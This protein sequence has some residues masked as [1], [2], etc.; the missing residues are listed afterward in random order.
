MATTGGAQRWMRWRQAGTRARGSPQQSLVPPAHRLKERNIAEELIP[1]QAKAVWGSI[2]PQQGAIAVLIYS[3]VVDPT[4]QPWQGRSVET[5]APLAFA[6]G[7]LMAQ[8]EAVDLS[9]PDDEEYLRHANQASQHADL[10]GAMI[11]EAEKILDD[12]VEYPPGARCSGREAI[13]KHRADRELAHQRK[14]DGDS[15]HQHGPVERYQIFLYALVL[16]ALDIMLLWRPLLNLGSPFDSAG[17]LTKWVIALLFA[18]AQA[19]TIEFV[20]HKYREKE[21][22]NTELRDAVKDYNRS[23]RRGGPAQRGLAVLTQ[24]PPA[25]DEL[26]AADE[27]L[28]AAHRLLLAMAIGVGFITVFRVAFLT[29]ASGRSII[30]ATVFGAFVGLILGAL[31]LLLGL[32]ACR[33]NQLGDRL[34]AGAAVVAH[35]EIQLLER[36]RQVAVARHSARLEL[37][38]A[39]TARARAA[40]TRSWVLNQYRQAFLLATGWLGLTKPPVNLADLVPPHQLEIADAATDQVDAVNDKL[41]VIDRWLAGPQIVLDDPQNEPS[42]SGAALEPPEATSAVRRVDPPLPGEPGRVVPA[43]HSMDPPPTEPR[44]LLAVAAVA[45]IGIAFG[46]AVIAPTPEGGTPTAITIPLSTLSRSR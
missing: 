46:A 20:V 40:A 29:R 39:E 15:R 36:G 45:A 2:D 6:S 26:P 12:T 22:E 38:D 11:E 1:D 28:R 25:V 30:E 23:A 17:A 27:K 19:A 44:W 18:G 13:A 24:Q 37:T 32:F 21:R 34:R 14:Q 43:L 42:T 16:S 9:R 8:Q 35:I 3:Q 33:G 5:A 41:T 31:V 10:A 7:L 4:G